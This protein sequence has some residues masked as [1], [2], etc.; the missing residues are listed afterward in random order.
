MKVVSAEFTFLQLAAWRDIL[1][2]S[3]LV[4]VLSVRTLDLDER[5]NRVELGI[6]AQSFEKVREELTQRISRLGIPVNAVRFE[7]LRGAGPQLDMAPPPTLQTGTTDP[8]AGGIQIVHWN[9][10]GCTLGF[11][12]QRSGVTGFVT[13]SH[14]SSMMYV[15]DNTSY[16]VG[17]VFAGVEV[18]DPYGYTCGLRTCRGSDANF[19]ANGSMPLAIGRILRTIGVNTGSITVDQSKP[20]FD[21]VQA[22]SSLYQGA[23]VHKVG[24][25]TGWTSGSIVS[26]CKDATPELYMVMT[27]GYEANYTRGNGDSGGPVFV[28]LASGD[29]TEV[30][31]VG[32]HS[33]ES[34][35]SSAI[36]AKL[37]RIQSDLGGT[38]NVIAHPP[39]P[40][41]GPLSAYVGGP[42]DANTSSFCTLRYWANSTGGSGAYSYAWSTDGSPVQ[43]SGGTYWVKFPTGGT[44]WV[45]VTVSDGTGAQITDRL[46]VV[47][48]SSGTD[49]N[50]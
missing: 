11:V 35:E 15:P 10:A 34:W 30:T 43:S 36:F 47:A 14:C 26:T 38:W 8:L 18:Q 28:R 6:E 40:P 50:N 32:I 44:Y 12:G 21:V 1:F 4:Q 2:D 42:V 49:C 9:N 5:E 46:Y 45:E 41:S 29:S 20:Y 37:E 19:V 7:S 22:G 25:T 3:V 39:T 17:G 31:L 23:T 13:N 16:Y 27:C 48:S 24:R 33:S